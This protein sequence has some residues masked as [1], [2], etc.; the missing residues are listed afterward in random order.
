MSHKVVLQATKREVIGKQVGALRRAGKLPAVLYGHQIK[1]M[2]IM[3]DPLEASRTLA[4]LTSSSLVTIDLDGQ[5]YPALVREKQVDFMKNN[6]LLHL[7]FQVISLTEKIRTKVGIEL[8][9]KAPAVKDFFAVIATGLTELE[10]E[11]MAQALPERIVVDISG[12]AEIGDAIHVRDVVLPD[13]VEVLDDKDEMIA[14]ASATK[15]EQI[16]AEAPGEAEAEPE[17]IESGKKE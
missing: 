3:L 16:V 4:H 15:E 6:R 13:M 1:S 17:V 10:V 5:E 9:G 8:V 14:V 11:C 12:L 2:P 7:D